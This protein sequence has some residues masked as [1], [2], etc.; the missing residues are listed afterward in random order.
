MLREFPFVLERAL[1]EQ[2]P[3]VQCDWPS[4]ACS[5]ALEQCLRLAI[6]RQGVFRLRVAQARCLRY[7]VWN[8]LRLTMERALRQPAYL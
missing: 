8:R 6:S 1:E 2:C 5:L 4:Y 3:S 7:L